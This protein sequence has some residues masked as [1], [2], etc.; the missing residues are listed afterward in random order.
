[1][2]LSTDP[3]EPLCHSPQLEPVSSAL[4]VWTG[5][6]DGAVLVVETSLV[7]QALVQGAVEDGLHSV[8]GSPQPGP[9][10]EGGGGRHD[11]VLPPVSAELGVGQA[12]VGGHHIH[13]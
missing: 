8:V 10:E 1:M 4:R 5:Q 7:L 2:T 3:H 6:S 12:G 11:G 9:V 13:S